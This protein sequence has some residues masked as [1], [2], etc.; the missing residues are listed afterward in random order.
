MS[1]IKQEALQLTAGG[2][3]EN[4]RE[5]DFYPTPEECTISLMNFLKLQPCSIWEPAC[6]NG[7]ISRVLESYG[8]EVFST[9]LFDYS[10]GT[11]EVDYLKFTPKL[12]CD[13]IITNPPFNRSV[14]FIE[15]A[16][17]E[18]DLVAMLLKSQYWHSKSRYDLFD[19]NPPAY[20]LPLTWR[21]NF[22]PEKG[23]APTME[24]HW[25]V[26]K[27]GDTITKYIPLKKPLNLNQ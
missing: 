19:S 12:R 10:Y 25:T 24:V 9:D 22:A 4:R 21:P 23:S 2:K 1:A 13:A 8:H 6:G 17:L 26:W 5:L 3:K 11:P 16:L 7:S 27:K 15:K 14:E 20:V 18:A